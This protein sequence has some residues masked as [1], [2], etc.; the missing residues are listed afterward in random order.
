MHYNTL[1][2]LS[3]YTLYTHNVSFEKSV[4]MLKLPDFL[5]YYKMKQL[6]PWVS[7]IIPLKLSHLLGE[8]SFSR[9]FNISTVHSDLN[10]V[11]G[12]RLRD[13]TRKDRG[14]FKNNYTQWE[15][16]L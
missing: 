9:S 16:S 8:R 10:Y 5:H 3:L 1:Y 13:W 11:N 14:S 12:W 4:K 7:W 15:D 2:M 6:S